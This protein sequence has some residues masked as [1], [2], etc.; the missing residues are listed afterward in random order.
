MSC[1]AEE[2]EC[3]GGGWVTRAPHPYPASRPP[4]IADCPGFIRSDP[5]FSEAPPAKP[6]S[7]INPCCFLLWLQWIWANPCSH[8]FVLANS[9]GAFLHLQ[10]QM[11]VFGL[12]CIGHKNLGLRGSV[13]GTLTCGVSADPHGTRGSSPHWHAGCMCL[14]QTP[15]HLCPVPY[16]LRTGEQMARNLSW[17]CARRWNLMWVEAPTPQTSLTE[18]KFKD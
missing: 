13:S 6:L 15:P 3:L 8:C 11:S 7:S 5:C 17:E 9:N 12:L 18:H 1:F 4:A 14:T 2:R 16:Q 10:A